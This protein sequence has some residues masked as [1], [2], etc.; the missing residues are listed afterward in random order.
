MK[1]KD[2]LMIKKENRCDSYW[3]CSNH[4]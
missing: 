3:R 1:G 2:A 4:F